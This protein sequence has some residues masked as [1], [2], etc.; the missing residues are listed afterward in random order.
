[1]LRVFRGMG[2]RDWLLMLVC[3][4][5]IV[6]QVYL[7]LKLPDYMSEITKLVETDGS[8]MSDVLTA[9]GKMLGVSAGSMACAVVSSLIAAVVAAGVSRDLR[10]R[11]YHSVSKFGPAEVD[12]FSTPSLVTRATNDV[13][14]VQ[15][16]LVMGLVLIVRAPVMAVW[17][18][19]KIAGKGI[20]WT[21]ATG[22]ALGLL[23]LMITVLVITC[24]P[25]FKAMQALTDDVNRVARE[26]LTGLRTV[27]AYNAE[28][29]QQKRFEDANRRLTGTQLFTSRM[30][31]SIMPFMTLVLN[32]LSLSIYWI[33][34]FL[35]NRPTAD[36][37]CSKPDI[38][39]AYMAAMQDKAQAAQLIASGAVDPARMRDYG[40]DMQSYAACMKDGAEALRTAVES[41]VD[42]FSNMV[43]FSSYAMQVIMAFLLCAMLLVLWPRAQASAQRIWQV[44]DTKPGITPG[45]RTEGAPGDANRGSVRFSDVSY[46]Y[47]GHKSPDLAGIDFEV[48]HGETLGVI[49]STGSGKSTLATLIP[50]LR[51]ADDGGT[52]SVDGVPVREW[53]DHELRRRIGYVTQKAIMLKGT[54]R[55]NIDLGV[56][57]ADEK[58]R[59]LDPDAL[60]WRAADIAQATEFITTRP[61]GM[62]SKVSQG[63]DNLSGGQ[64]Q[65]LNIS[66]AIRTAPEILILD[67]STSALDMKTD[68]KLR[69]A[70]R[71]ELAGTTVIMIAQRVSSIMDADRI[72]VLDEGRQ[73]GYGTHAE[74]MESC[75][76][77]REIAEGQLGK[78][79]WTNGR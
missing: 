66:R 76:E 47:P 1:M 41:R 27:R 32:G 33:G 74:L 42:V 2:W 24:L 4:A 68:A 69:A 52:V 55:E 21:E 5:F 34:A 35:L 59:G 25:K 38:P 8:K 58:A 61:G 63:G 31:A 19:C 17:A 28:D 54:I 43:V 23:L 44:I 65:R 64:K 78:E 39:A 57:P 60:D 6:L 51:E 50:R 40:N 62:D 20:E 73:V 46:T 48:G 3:T 75:G 67:D 72:I 29:Y 30:T 22:L 26:E 11:Q 77:Y 70:L 37:S 18:I 14:Q 7:D 71:S 56:D 79:A 16:F 36:A 10:S 15:M 45:D 12:G 53:D 9:G 49:G 13:T